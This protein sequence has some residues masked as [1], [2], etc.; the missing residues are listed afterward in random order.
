MPHESIL[1]APRHHGI[2][3]SGVGSLLDVVFF[4]HYRFKDIVLLAVAL[5][6]H[7]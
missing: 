2:A 5:W 1:R 7:I 6:L 3:D 4:G